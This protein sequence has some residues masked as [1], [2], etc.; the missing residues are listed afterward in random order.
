MRLLIDIDTSNPALRAAAF[1]SLLN[2]LTSIN[3]AWLRANRG[4]VRIYQSGVRYQDE[5]LGT[6][7][8]VDIPHVL[9]QGWGD[10]AHLCCWRA[11]E[12]RVTDSIAAIP[13]LCLQSASEVGRLVVYHVRVRFPDGRVEDP[14]VYL[15]PGYPL[16][17]PPRSARAGRAVKSNG[18]R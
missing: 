4:T 7:S 14:S 5:P 18:G 10:C 11:A 6:E 12:L 16:R 3:E 9:R 13:E 15:T 1:V 2:S 17:V 8:F